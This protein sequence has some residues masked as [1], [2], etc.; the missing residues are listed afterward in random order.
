MHRKLSNFE[1]R[2]FD[3]VVVGGGISGA[4]V[5]HDAAQRGL[6]VALVE[7]GDFGG[8]T[9]AASS[10]LLHGGVRYLQQLRLY[11]VRESARERLFLKTIAPHLSHW[12][13]FLIPTHRGVRRGRRLLQLGLGLHDLLSPGANGHVTDPAVRPPP[14]R[15]YDCDEL[16]RLV[17]GLCA[18]QDITGAHLIHESHLHSSERMTLAFVKSAVRA[19]AE[20]ANYVGAV[21]VVRVDGRVAGVK[22]T[23]TIGG[24]QLD[25]RALLVVNAA[26]PW[27]P[28][29]NT[30]LRLGSL[31]RPV[32]GF[33]KGSHIVARQIFDTHAVA[34]PTARS[35][36]AILHRGGRHIFAIPWRGHSLIG[37]TDR[38]YEGPLDDVGPTE[39]DVDDLIGDVNRALPNVDLKRDDVCHAFAGLYPLTAERLQGDVYQ[40]SGDYQLVDH[41]REDGVDGVVSVLGAKYTTA[42]RL[43][44]RATTLVCAKLGRGEAV[45]RTMETPVVGGA[46]DDLETFTRDAVTRHAG[47]LDRKTVEHLVRHYGSEADAVVASTAGSAA[48]L[49]RLSPDRESIEAEVIFGVEREMALKLADVVFRRTGLGTLGHPGHRCLQRCAEV[50]AERLGW[51][52]TETQRQ[53]QLTSSMFPLHTA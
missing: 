12:V 49:E 3:V 21:D 6:A 26:G 29:L 47:H 35:A 45:C 2:V 1:G 14:N 13:P 36:S 10:K 42:R 52:E 22:A 5:A 53:V 30:R 8:A 18:G 43:A 4:C 38:P 46:I 16:E 41:G 11:K 7:R 44:E 27:L 20:V 50:M 15:F 34:L 31:R 28:G 40:G 33:S 51:T 39:Q 37:T 24:G 25:I 48:G 32:T 17:P 23:D 19:G 9:S